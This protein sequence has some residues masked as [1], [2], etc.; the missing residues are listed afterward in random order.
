MAA[1]PKKLFVRLKPYNP[2]RGHV[3]RRYAYRGI[4]FYEGRWYKVP[5]ALAKE[6]A[7]V[8]QKHGDE[9]SPFAFDVATERQAHELEERER[10]KH[11]EEIRRVRNADVVSASEVRD[12]DVRGALT[13]ADLKGDD[14][15]DVDDDERPLGVDMK[16]TKAEL[17]DAAEVLG[18]E[19]DEAWTKAEI[20]E[21][22][23]AGA[24]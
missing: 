15:P 21:A 20:L 4:R 5:T 17:L 1:Q 10:R 6:L 23:E 16:N 12:G 24:S 14:E 19:V 7:Q 13:T 22:L 9:D 2:K 11:E 8:H 3:L 18:V